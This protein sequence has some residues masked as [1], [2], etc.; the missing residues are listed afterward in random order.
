MIP[1]N[2]QPEN[3]FN[4]KISID[5]N[6]Q[7]SIMNSPNEQKEKEETLVLY[8]SYGYIRVSLKELNDKNISLYNFSQ[9]KQNSYNIV[10]NNEPNNDYKSTF[11][12]SINKNNTKN[13]IN[14]RIKTLS[15]D[16]KIYEIKNQ[17]IN[18]S[19]NTLI[20]KLME[21]KLNN[22]INKKLNDDNN[23]YI[24][25]NY[26]K[27]EK[28]KELTKLS[29]FRLYSSRY[30][31]RELNT[32]QN[33]YENNIQEDELLIFLPELKIDFSSSLKGKAIE[34]TPDKKTAL[35]INTDDPQFVLGSHGYNNGRHYFEVTLLTD[36][37][38]WSIIL[39]VCTKESEDDEMKLDVKNFYG[40]VL[41]DGKKTNVLAANENDLINYG[42]CCE[43]HDVIGV[44]I[45]FSFNGVYIT[46]YRNKKSLGKA[47][48]M[49]A[50]NKKYYPA[51]KLGLCGSK[52]KI[53]NDVYFPE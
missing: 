39:G 52:V 27:N 19:L 35:K 22:N 21:Q 25:N 15:G 12:G 3:K 28:Q 40:Y 24:D 36:P 20:D 9:Y 41:S 33:F 26:N 34:L 32:S 53:T 1:N 11:H 17:S 2:N 45:D 50:K 14:I 13:N 43:I 4:N 8:S 10:N 5:S 47:F 6:A 49:L 51:V 16:R 23:F 44:L 38:M 37:M 48:C 7:I 46:F 30:G 18:T 29:Q 31:I 42:E